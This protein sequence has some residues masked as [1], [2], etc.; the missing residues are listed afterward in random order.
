MGKRRNLPEKQKRKLGLKNN[1]KYNKMKDHRFLVTCNKL[2][3]LY[4][5]KKG[6][7]QECQ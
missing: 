3:K 2:V 4:S 6:K 1:A 7:K 5:P